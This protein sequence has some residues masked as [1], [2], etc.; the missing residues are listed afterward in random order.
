MISKTATVTHVIQLGAVTVR[1]RTF[2][3]IQSGHC[4][5]TV[6]TLEKKSIGL[7]RVS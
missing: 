5:K 6:G 1:V 7:T 4:G 2:V 3:F